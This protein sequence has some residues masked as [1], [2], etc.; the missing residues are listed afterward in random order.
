M[1]IGDV[2]GS[3]L[4]GC[5]VGPLARFIVPGADPVPICV[6]LVRRGATGTTTHRQ[7]S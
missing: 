4:V 7:I 1:S 6:R 5:I 2:F 3:L